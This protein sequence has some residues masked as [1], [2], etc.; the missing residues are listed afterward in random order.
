MLPQSAV[1][2]LPLKSVVFKHEQFIQF[3][4]RQHYLVEIFL[5]LRETILNVKVLNFYFKFLIFIYNQINWPNT[6]FE[7]PKKGYTISNLKTYVDFCFLFLF[8]STFEKTITPKMVFV[9]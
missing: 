3:E 9:K 5:S 7:R 6:V 8:R 4:L 1:S 2:G